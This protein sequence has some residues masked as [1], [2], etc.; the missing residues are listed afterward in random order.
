MFKYRCLNGPKPL[1]EG[2]HSF[3]LGNSEWGMQLVIRNLADQRTI[4]RRYI[5]F[6]ISIY[7]SQT[8]FE[9]RF[10]NSI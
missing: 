7:G 5:R 1:D 4:T 8:I 9:F 3:L 2:L 10:R 6:I